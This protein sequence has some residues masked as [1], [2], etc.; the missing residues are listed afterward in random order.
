MII[1][2]T[3]RAGGKLWGSNKTAPFDLL[4]F[5]DDDNLIPLIPTGVLTGS[6]GVP[7]ISRNSLRRN[8]QRSEDRPGVG[9]LLSGRGAVHH[10]DD[11]YGTGQ[12]SAWRRH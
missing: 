4:T 1:T 11:L 5:G 7:P 2:A 3:R 6:P 12:A 9:R 10:S 8:H